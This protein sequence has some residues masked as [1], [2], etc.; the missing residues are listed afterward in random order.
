MP[1]PPQPRSEPNFFC[2]TAWF[3]LHKMI[4]S[5]AASL[6][7]RKQL[8]GIYQM[9]QIGIVCRLGTPLALPTMINFAK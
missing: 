9:K 8:L 7:R 4:V 3:L 2:T 6:A 1:T 5:T